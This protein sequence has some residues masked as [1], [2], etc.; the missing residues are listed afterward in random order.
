MMARRWCPGLVRDMAGDG[1]I[2]TPGAL[3]SPAFSTR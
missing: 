1:G 3:M 2:W